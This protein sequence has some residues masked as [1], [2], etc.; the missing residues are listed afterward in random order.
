MFPVVLKPQHFTVKSYFRCFSDKAWIMAKLATN[1]KVIVHVNQTYFSGCVLLF[2]FPFH[3]YADRWW[4]GVGGPQQLVSF[5]HKLYWKVFRC[6]IPQ[7]IQH[8]TCFYFVRFY[9]RIPNKWECQ[10]SALAV[11]AAPRILHFLW[12]LKSLCFWDRFK[13]SHIFQF[14]KLIAIRFSHCIKYRNF[15]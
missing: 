5:F 7:F 1:V 8:L 12:I 15:T 11:G 13:L 10:M 6:N 3:F 2:T 9:S 14:W 4:R